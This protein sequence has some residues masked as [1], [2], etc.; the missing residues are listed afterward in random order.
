MQELH[1]LHNR[2]STATVKPTMKLPHS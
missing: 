1:S 2:A